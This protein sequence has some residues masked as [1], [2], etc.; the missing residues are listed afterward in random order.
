MSVITRKHGLGAHAV[1]PLSSL[2]RHFSKVLALVFW[3][4]VVGLYWW[5]TDRYHL[6]PEM[7]VILLQELFTAKIYGPLLFIVFFALQ[8]LVFFPSFVLGIAGGML[9]GPVAG[10]FFVMIGANSAANV[11]YLVG[12][13][14]GWGVVEVHSNQRGGWRSNSSVLAGV[15]WG[16][17]EVHSN[18]GGLIQRYM[19]RARHHTFETIL[20]LHLLF[21]PFDL[22]NYL[23]GFFRMH[24][25][26]FAVATVIGS[27]PGVLSFV[28]FGASLEGNLLAGEP[29]LNL[30]LLLKAGLALMVGIILAQLVKRRH[31]KAGHSHHI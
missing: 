21:V 17:V 23:A 30:P 29:E 16:M 2:Y 18:Q 26:K 20:I 1:G 22:V 15:E 7:K 3:A 11:S 12:R 27:I 8:P 13:F 24:W 4:T 28:L 9:Y 31:P 19:N 6:S 10:I 5:M 14:F 25:L